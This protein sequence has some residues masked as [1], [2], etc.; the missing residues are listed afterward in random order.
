MGKQKYVICTTGVSLAVNL[1]LDSKE[2]YTHRNW[3]GADAGFEKALET[4]LEK[5]LNVNMDDTA[6]QRALSAEINT[7]SRLGVGKGDRV[8]L[9]S[10]DTGNGQ[11]CSK[12]VR[13]CLINWYGLKD[14]DV[15]IVRIEG[16]QVV[17]EKAFKEKG[18]KNLVSKIIDIKE[19][20]QDS[21]EVIFNPT[22]GYKGVVPFVSII[23]MIFGIKIVYMFVESNSLL[24]LPPLPISFNLELFNRV[25]PALKD[26]IDSPRLSRWEYLRRIEDYA[27]EEENLFMSFVETVGDDVM[28]SPLAFSLYEIEENRAKPKVSDSVMAKL[29]KMKDTESQKKLKDMIGES[30]SIFWR[31]THHHS[32]S[33]TDLSVFKQGGNAC[34][35]AGFLQNGVIFVT[36]AFGDHDEYE[37]RLKGTYTKD[38]LNAT[39]ADWEY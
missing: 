13:R 1:K 20:N 7:L 28:I 18:L 30:S 35:I 2:A 10:S 12:A 17:D 39:Y 34:R 15:S 38:Y 27:Q 14:K 32:F 22:G 25:K 4:E 26:L 8:A 3:D 19:S 24:T 5:Y 31:N 37:K 21:Y 6:K 33:G 36:H 23:G 9:L 16:M 29:D 11:L